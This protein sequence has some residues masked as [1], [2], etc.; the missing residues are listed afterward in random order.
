[1][2]NTEDNLENK[3]LRRKRSVEVTRKQLTTEQIQQF[4]FIDDKPVVPERQFTFEMLSDS[5]ENQ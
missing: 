5:I 3:A 2:L 1:M 4:I